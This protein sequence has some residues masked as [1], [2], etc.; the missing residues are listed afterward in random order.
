MISNSILFKELG[1]DQMKKRP[2][3]KKAASD[4]PPPLKPLSDTNFPHPALDHLIRLT[5]NTGL[6]Q[7]A[8]GIIPNREHGYCTD[9]NARAVIAMT[10]HYAQ[11]ADHIALEL[12]NVYLSFIMHAQ[13]NDGSIRNFMNYDRTWH[14]SEPRSDAFGRVLWALGTLLATPPSPAYLSAP[15]AYFDRSV[16]LVQNQFPRGL[17]Y[18]ILGISGY[19]K[20]F[21]Q[22]DD[23]KDQMRKAADIL[24]TYYNEN[25][26]PD[27]QWFEHILTYDNAILPCALFVAGMDLNNQRYLDVAGA[28]CKF[29]LENT[30]NGQHFSFIGSHGWYKRGKPIAQF[31]Q[32]PIEA[33]S[34]IMM[35]KAAYDATGKND[36]LALQTKAFEWFLGSNDLNLPLYDS[37]TK[38][39]NDALMIDGIN[40]NQGAESTLSFLLAALTV[41]ES[42]PLP[43]QKNE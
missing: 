11:Y 35:L 29:L 30:Y 25:T 31:N 6:L 28:T 38:G 37:A 24:V 15:Q 5:D 39:C 8:A 21:P 33:A 14:R 17:A 43:R 1:T 16:W 41:S 13:S 4:Q 34:T 7:H 20:Q 19:L 18:S 2:P 36:F 26:S 23:I 9:D 10:K 32:Q 22:A 40:N 42:Y 27:W 3:K 12:L